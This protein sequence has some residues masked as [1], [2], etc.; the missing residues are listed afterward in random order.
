MP[1]CEV[2]TLHLPLRYPRTRLKIDGTRE[3]GQFSRRFA[4]HA[5]VAR[6]FRYATVNTC[7]AWCGR[8]ALGSR[9]TVA[10]FRLFR[11]RRAGMDVE[12]DAHGLFDDN[13]SLLQHHLEFRLHLFEAVGDEASCCRRVVLTFYAVPGSSFLPSPGGRVRSGNSARNWWYVDS[14]MIVFIGRPLSG[15]PLT[16]S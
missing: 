12:D 3:R 2:Q 5:V 1:R 9:R 13:H 8:S 6:S 4:Y 15:I 7:R 11:R 14:P 10:V 16:V